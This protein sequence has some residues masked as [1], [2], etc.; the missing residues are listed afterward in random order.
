MSLVVADE[1]FF[2]EFHQDVRLSRAV[3]FASRLYE[4]SRD[5]SI[6]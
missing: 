1:P 4:K 3:F 6:S 2:L 5:L